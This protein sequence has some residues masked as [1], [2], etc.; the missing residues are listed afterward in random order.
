MFMQVNA[1]D[2]SIPTQSSLTV[3]M[4]AA[5]ITKTFEKQTCFYMKK[6]K[7]ESFYNCFRLSNEP[8]D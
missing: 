1:T 5:E 7:P 6:Q 8:G 3:K 2:R 4:V